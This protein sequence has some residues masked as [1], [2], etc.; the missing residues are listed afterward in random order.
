MI[1]NIIDRFFISN[2]ED[3]VRE[4]HDFID[5]LKIV[6]L[7]LLQKGS[8][9]DVKLSQVLSSISSQ[10]Q[11]V[12][13]VEESRDLWVG[14]FG[15]LHGRPAV[16]EFEWFLVGAHVKVHRVVILRED[17]NEIVRSGVLQK[18]SSSGFGVLPPSG[19][20]L[21]TVEEH[22]KLTIGTIFAGLWDVNVADFTHL[23]LLVSISER[24]LVES[25]ESTIFRMIVRL[26]LQSIVWV[27]SLKQVVGHV[28]TAIGEAA[29]FRR[30]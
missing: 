10:N 22:D 20:L 16:L 4:L 14:N 21:A 5:V 24:R 27:Q 15:S 7:F 6:V 9:L 2:L 18:S 30:N 17:D 3:I 23:C 28:V 25:V 19:S 12:H 11:G 13:D 26:L 1:L 8:L 29:L